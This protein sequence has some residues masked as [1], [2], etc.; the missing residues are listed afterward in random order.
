MFVLTLFIRVWKRQVLETDSDLD[1]P[2]TAR[3]PPQGY[4][5]LHV[6]QIEPS[7]WFKQ[8]AFNLF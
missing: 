8:N 6:W 7:W 5:Q 3:F 1:C 2:N 4:L